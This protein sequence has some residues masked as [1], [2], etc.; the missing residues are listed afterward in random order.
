MKVLGVGR[1]AERKTK[2]ISEETKR[3]ETQGP[4]Q[5]ILAPVVTGPHK[6]ISDSHSPKTPPRNRASTPWNLIFRSSAFGGES[7]F[8][9]REAA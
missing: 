7:T 2:R 1:R 9:G 4:D 5:S 3:S 8:Y 6:C